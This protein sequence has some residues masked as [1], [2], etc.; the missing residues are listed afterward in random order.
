MRF[1]KVGL[2]GGI[3][4]GKSTVAELWRGMGA[5]IIDSDILARRALEPGT[6]TYAQVV[7]QFGKQILNADGTVNRPALGNIVFADECRRQQLNA[8]IHPAVREMWA[9]A[10]TGLTGVAVVAIPLLFEVGAENEFDCTVAVGCST[11]TQ[12]AR[13]RAS[14]LDE[15]QARARIN[16]QMPVQQ[17]MDRAQ[18][19]IWN[20]GSRAVLARQAEMIW[21]KIKES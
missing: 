1:T 17:K 6:P 13:L 5:T 12:V 16:A 7:E 15:G 4:T 11:P 2:T 10:L 3:A 21:S 20:D 9:Q 8:I 14:G 18:Y 19:A